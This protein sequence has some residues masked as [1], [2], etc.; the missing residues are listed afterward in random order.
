MDDPDAPAG[1]WLHWALYDL[2]G[3]VQELPRNVATD[4]TLENS[5]KQT[6]NDFARIGYSGPCPPAG[7]PH[8]Y[9]FKLY[10]LDAPTGLKAGATKAE[11][12][13]AMEGH[14]LGQTQLTGQFGRQH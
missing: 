14:I 10:A 6:R 3:D 1:T 9:V 13:H 2:P 7:K 8:R 4:P 11:V 5:A 12:Q